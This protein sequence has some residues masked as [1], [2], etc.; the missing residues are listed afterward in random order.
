M[1]N[2]FT[3]SVVITLTSPGSVAF[4]LGGFSIR[5]YG[6]F[7]GIGFLFAYFVAEKLIIKSKLSLEHFNNLVFLILIFSI[8]FAR[9][10]FVFLNLDYFKEH[11]GEIYKIWYGGQ[12]LHGGI[13][14]GVLALYFYCRIK[15]IDLMKYLDIAGVTVP[16]A[17]AIGR[18]GNFFNNEAFGLPV[19][20]SLIRLFVPYEFR[21]VNYLSSEYF[22]PTFLYESFFDFF[23]FIFLYKNYSKWKSTPGKIFFVYLLMYSIIRFFLEFIR[24]DSLYLFHHFPAAHVVSLVLIAVSVIFLFKNRRSSK[25]LHN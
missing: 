5:W 12:S 23:I 18:W 6:I 21:P 20:D 24:V 19:S 15:K 7:I 3:E 8:V 17:Q 9:L 2:N 22:H 11:A 4:E 16:L 14:G 25:M 10:W 13:F 1:Q